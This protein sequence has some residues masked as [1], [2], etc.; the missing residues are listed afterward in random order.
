MIYWTDKFSCSCVFYLVFMFRS[1]LFLQWS[2]GKLELIICVC[3]NCIKFFITL[4]IF[5]ILLHLHLILYV[6]E[7][8]WEPQIEVTTGGFK[9]GILYMQ[10]IYLT[11]WAIKFSVWV[12]L[13]VFD[14]FELVTALHMWHSYLITVRGIVLKRFTFTWLHFT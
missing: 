13:S 6:L 1:Y 12:C 2:L 3:R 7:I 5:N 4:P 11:H 14:H 9:I 8:S 10:C